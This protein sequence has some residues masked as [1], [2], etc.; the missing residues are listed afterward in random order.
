[1]FLFP[2]ASRFFC[3]FFAARF[4][5]FQDTDKVKNPRGV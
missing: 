4:Q 1:L 5:W 3:F 2:F